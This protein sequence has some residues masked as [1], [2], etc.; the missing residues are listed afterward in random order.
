MDLELFKD[1]CSRLP[2]GVICKSKYI[3]YDEIDGDDVE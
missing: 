2:Y 1:L 3:E